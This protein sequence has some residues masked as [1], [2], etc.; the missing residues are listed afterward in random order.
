MYPVS[1]DENNPVGM[2]IVRVNAVDMDT[3]KN[4]KIFYTLDDSALTY[5]SIDPTTG[6]IAALTSL[7]REV[8]PMLKIN[9]T[10]TDMGEPPRSSVTTVQLTVIDVD[11]EAPQFYFTEY[12]FSVDEGQP[13]GT[14]VG[15]VTAYDRDAPPFNSIFY[16]IHSSSTLSAP[17]TMHSITGKISTLMPLDREQRSS[18]AL[19]VTASGSTNVGTL[20]TVNTSVRVRVGD[21]ND[22]PPRFQFPSSEDNEIAISINTPV[23]YAFAHVKAAD[24]D[25]GVNAKL[26]YYVTNDGDQTEFLIDAQTGALQVVTDLEASF[27]KDEEIVTLDVSAVDGGDPALSA[28][29]HLRVVIRRN[30][31]F[32][33]T[34]PTNRM[35]LFLASDDLAIAL[36]ITLA[37][38]IV[39]VSISI[40]IIC[41]VRRRRIVK[42]SEAN[43]FIEMMTYEAPPEAVVVKGKRITKCRTVY[44]DQDGVVLCSHKHQTNGANSSKVMD[45]KLNSYEGFN[46]EIQVSFK[47]NRGLNI[48]NST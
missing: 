28:T 47:I 33:P 19:T 22:N 14:E 23:G 12:T 38:I 2:S 46:S 1:V 48:C 34:A 40:A 16:S 42:R 30:L 13:G 37:T 20:V 10:A 15:T 6:V 32:S 29:E 21:I 44:K 36:T 9:V 4:C 26:T 25:T 35:Y 41:L 39:A 7:D 11:D 31:Q 27:N 24:D 18:Y 8:T 3:G 45:T 5:F 17:F 43:E